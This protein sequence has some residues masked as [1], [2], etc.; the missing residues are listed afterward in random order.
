MSQIKSKSKVKY[1]S[2]D[3]NLNIPNGQVQVLVYYPDDKRIKYY[4]VTRDKTDRYFLYLVNNNKL[5]KL[6]SA[7]DPTTFKEVYPER[8]DD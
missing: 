3:Y 2:G 6:K 5:T 7:R 4:I 8:Y 1:I